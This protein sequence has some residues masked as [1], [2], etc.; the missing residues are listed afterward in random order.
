MNMKF[1]YQNPEMKRIQKQK[2]SKMNRLK[3]VGVGV[4]LVLLLVGGIWGYTAF[5]GMTYS[6]G[7]RS[8]VI[9]KFSYK[10]FLVKTWEGE[11][12]RGGSMMEGG[13]AEKFLFS[14]SDPEVVKKV[15][16]AESSGQK[17]EL[18]YR[19]Q[20]W[21]QWWKGNTA[22]FIVDVEEVGKNK[23]E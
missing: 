3:V 20:M 10:G 6:E 21:P 5:G 4:V 15:E 22:Y 13:M 18:T 2:E 9:N 17:V 19:Q 12:Q 7:S 11:L 23:Q 16:E 1:I 8:G 14:V